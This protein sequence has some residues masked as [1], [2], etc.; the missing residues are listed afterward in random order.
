MPAHV[1]TLNEARTYIMCIYIYIYVCV[2][3]NF[4]LSFSGKIEVNFEET[5][6]AYHAGNRKSFSLP[7]HEDT[8]GETLNNIYMA[9]EGH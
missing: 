8:A 3:F 5:R 1:T 9:Q 4:F 6:S 7:H 2:F